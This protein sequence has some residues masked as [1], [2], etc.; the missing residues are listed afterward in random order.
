MYDRAKVIAGLLIFGIVVS[1]P[2]WY[3]WAQPGRGGPPE[4]VKPKDADHC[5]ES[6]EFMRARHMALLN[7]WR[8]DFVRNGQRVYVSSQ[9]ES[10]RIS[11]TGTCLQC[12][13]ARA[14]FC[15][16]CHT[17]VGENPP[18]WNCHLDPHTPGAGGS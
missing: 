5:V 10:F 1:F 7:Q 4:L 3:D 6:L 16:R 8:D 9:G 2:F 15:D 11:L 17:Y 12:H 14:D 18:C 13:G